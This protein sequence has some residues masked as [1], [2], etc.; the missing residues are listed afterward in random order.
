MRL[1]HHCHLGVVVTALG[2]V[3]LLLL[4][5]MLLLIRGATSSVATTHRVTAPTV[6]IT[7]V[8]LRGVSTSTIPPSIDISLQAF[9][10]CSHKIIFLLLYIF[11]IS[12]AGE[13]HILPLLF[14]ILFIVNG[15]K[16]LF[17]IE[18]V[19]SAAIVI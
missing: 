10:E 15:M 13:V 9:I 1:V 3:L 2:T 4:L 8:I 12:V 14:L 16:R 5:T 17:F 7:N 18:L 19:E 6:I 11:L